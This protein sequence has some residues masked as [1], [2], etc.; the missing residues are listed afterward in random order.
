[1]QIAIFLVVPVALVRYAGIA[2]SERG[3][4]GLMQ[5]MPVT[6]SEIAE[7][8]DIQDPSLPHENLRAGVYYVAKLSE[9]F[10]D[11]K[12][13]DRIR[14]VLAA[15]NAGPSRIYDAQEL[16]FDPKEQAA[17][18]EE[19]ARDVDREV[20]RNE[21][22]IIQEMGASIHYERRMGRDFTVASLQE[23]GFAAIFLAIGAQK[24]AP[25]TAPTVFHRYTAPTR[26]PI[27]WSCAALTRAA[28][29]K[30]AP[31]RV[32][33]MSSDVASVTK[34]LRRPPTPQPKPISPVAVQARVRSAL[35]L[36]RQRD[37]V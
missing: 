33:G 12:G 23:S 30:L 3:A 28:A 1:M 16:G 35:E 29:G 37:P 15:Y 32:V 14:L 10:K 24:S 13:E 36:K 22:E 34:K 6:N 2:V 31:S 9:L 19:I 8:I 18:F 17:V 21:V 25:L 26:R 11:V 20:L 7:E 5:I 4:Q 27:A